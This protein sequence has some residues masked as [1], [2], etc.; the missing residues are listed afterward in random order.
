MFLSNFSPPYS[1][2]PLAICLHK[3]T[4][5]DRDDVNNLKFMPQGHQNVNLHVLKN[6]APVIRQFVHEG[7]Q[8]GWSSHR[9]NPVLA[10]SLSK[11]RKL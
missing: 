11:K 7:V 6:L 3:P 8:H 4:A 9:V 1:I 10:I 2:V 5:Q